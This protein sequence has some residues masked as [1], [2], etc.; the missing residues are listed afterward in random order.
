MKSTMAQVVAVSRQVNA[1]DARG[2]LVILRDLQAQGLE[3]KV[4]D[5]KIE[6]DPHA[7]LVEL[8]EGTG[9]KV[10]TYEEGGVDE[11]E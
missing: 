9:A 2:K 10:V 3:K 8:L 5:R 1:L 4:M 11:R 6:I 7:K